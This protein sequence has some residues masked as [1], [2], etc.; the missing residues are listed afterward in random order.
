VFVVFTSI[1]P[2]VFFLLYMHVGLLA[3]CVYFIYFL[4]TYVSMYIYVCECYVCVCVCTCA[5]ACMS[6]ICVCVCVCTAG[7]FLLVDSFIHPHDHI[8]YHVFLAAPGRSLT[9]PGGRT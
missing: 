5:C 9:E 7:C 8:A 3:Y 6:M 1:S 4:S 2:C